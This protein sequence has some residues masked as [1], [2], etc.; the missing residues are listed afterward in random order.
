MRGFGIYLICHFSYKISI[1]NITKTAQKVPFYRRNSIAFGDVVDEFVFERVRVQAGGV[2]FVYQ[3]ELVAFFPIAF[4]QSF[5]VGKE[6]GK[7]VLAYI[8]FKLVGQ[9]CVRAS[10]FARFD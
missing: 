10:R 4:Y 7:R 5:V 2:V 9:H 6:G 3:K 1:S 8:A